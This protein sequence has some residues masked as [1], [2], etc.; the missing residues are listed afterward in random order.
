MRGVFLQAKSA[1]SVERAARTRCEYVPV[2]SG[3]APAAHGP[4]SFFL[5]SAHGASF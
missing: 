1:Q 3:A 5:S 2:R 4:R